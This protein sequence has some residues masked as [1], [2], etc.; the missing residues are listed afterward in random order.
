[1]KRYW[2]IALIAAAPIL[3]ASQE[4]RSRP[5]RGSTSDQERAPRERVQEKNGNALFLTLSEL[6]LFEKGE[7]SQISVKRADG[8]REAASRWESDDPGIAAVDKSGY[9]TPGHTGSTKIRAFAADG[10]K[11][12]DCVVTVSKP[13][14]WGS[15]GGKDSVVVQNQWVYFANPFDENRLYKIR[16][17]GERPVRLSDDMPRLINVAGRWIYYY[18]TN[19]ET[20]PGLY[21]ISIDGEH[22]KLLND[23]DSIAY[24]RVNINGEAFYLTGNGEAFLLQTRSPKASAIKLF[25]EKEIFSM[26][27]NDHHIFYTRHWEDM[28]Q[29]QGGGGIFSFNLKS[30]KKNRHLPVG[31]NTSPVILDQ[32]EDKTAYYCSYGDH[33][34]PV[35][36]G[37]PSG[38][39]RDSPSTGWFA[40][41]SLDEEDS[42]A[43]SIRDLPTGQK[44]SLDGISTM[45]SLITKIKLVSGDSI[46][47]VIDGWI[48]YTRGRELRR[49]QSDGKGDQIVSAPP[50][51]VKEWCFGEEYLFYLTVDNR[52]FRTLTDGRTTSE[53]ILKR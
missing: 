28:R 1:M 34:V 48:Y 29:P 21:L 10:R 17:A 35:R 42:A 47:W 41:V 13:S 5:Q 22:R 43:S 39:F 51:E 15:I 33:S 44:G 45:K 12:N 31:I 6:D 18:N 19:P 26:A 40:I 24:L 2:L 53:I 38:I 46:Q 20:I 27:V 37:L 25:D 9:V 36:K 14:R 50:T 23:R 16:I 52:L 30:K 32:N 11:T 3:Y 49:M 8:I 4:Q 7:R